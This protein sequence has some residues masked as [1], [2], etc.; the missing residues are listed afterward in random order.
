[1][2][3]AFNF[4]R[5]AEDRNAENVLVISGDKNIAQNYADAF[6]ARFAQSR[7]FVANPYGAKA[8]GAAG[9]P[10]NSISIANRQNLW[11]S[12]WSL[13]VGAHD[14]DVPNQ[15]L[16]SAPKATMHKSEH[17]PLLIHPIDPRNF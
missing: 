10:K 14:E 4:T 8:A 5:S 17:F 12:D 7:D 16:L 1:V 15:V 3:G 2:T 9:T 6:D 13:I 11:R